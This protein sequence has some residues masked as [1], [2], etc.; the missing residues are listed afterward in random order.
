MSSP[1]ITAE[2]VS[3]SAAGQHILGPLSF[4]VKTGE[5]LALIGPNGAGKTSLLRLVTGIRQPTAGTLSFDGHPYSAFKAK[6]LARRIAYVPQLRPARIPL[7]VEEMV[8]QGRFPFLSPFQLTPA[9]EDFQA[10]AEALDTVGL[11]DLRLRPVNQLSGGERQAVFIAA[12]LAGRAPV[13]VLDEPTTHLDP[14]HQRDIVRIL[15]RLRRGHRP[16]VI[17][18]THDLRLAALSDRAFALSRGRLLALEDPRKI[19]QPESLNRLF[20]APFE[21][22]SLEEES[23]PLVRLK[24]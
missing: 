10:V 4:Q 8:L 21:V 19:L 22:F 12:A 15:Q 24:E 13:L 5:C 14:R 17:L 23:V 2:G 9:G 16:T 1:I 3:W 11:T 6:E 7:L 20:E 18:A